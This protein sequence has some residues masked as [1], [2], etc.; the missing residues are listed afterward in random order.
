MS[1]PVSRIWR[2]LAGFVLA[3][4]LVFAQDLPD[5]VRALPPVVITATKGARDL[6]EVAVPMQVLTRQEIAAI[7]A[8][9]LSD[10]LAEQPGLALVQEFGTGVQVQG[11]APDYT[12]ILIDGE[13]VIGRQGGTLNLDRL[14]VGGIER[15]EV[16]K[17]PSS[18]LYGSEA[19][20]GVINL[21]T[22]RPD[23]PLHLT[24][25]ARYETH[26]TLDAT[27]EAAFQ[28]K[29]LGGRVLLNRYGSD[30]YDLARHLPGATTP[31]FTDYTASAHLHV[32]AS[33]RTDLRFA[34]RYGQEQQRNAVGVVDQGIL[35]EYEEAS[36]RDDWSTS[37]TLVYRPGP[38]WRLQSTLY[39]AR[40]MTDTA[41]R[42]PETDV[43]LTQSRFDQFYGKS[44]TQLD[45][46]AGP[47]HLATFGGGLVRESIAADRV[48]GGFRR[49]VAG[50]AFAQ[51]EWQASARLGLVASTRLDAH[52]DYA[53]RVSP[54]LAVRYRAAETLHLRASLGSGFRAPTFQQRYMDFTNAVGGY[55]VYGANEARTVLHELDTQGLLATY[56]VDPS[57]LGEL[58]PESARSLNVGGTYTRPHATLHVNLFRNHVRDLIETGLVAF[59]TN[60]QQVFSYFN[61]HRIYTQGVEVEAE[62][63]PVADLAL[64]LGYQYLDTADRDV[65]A[66]LDAGT[67]FTRDASNRDRRATRRDYGGLFNRSRHSSTLH[68][69]YERRGSTVAL[70]GIWRGRYGHADANGNLILDQATEYVPGYTLWHVTLTQVLGTRLHLQTGLKNLFDH[71]NPIL[72]PS[73]PGR[74]YFV[75]LRL[76]VE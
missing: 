55:A 44:E 3:P 17:G 36:R 13:P 1:A 29:R 59:R 23:A 8:T 15:V 9:R 53:A 67:V 20:A 39:A 72:I 19:L 35:L 73:L 54:K 10:L 76:E 2:L 57:R 51:H 46:I 18:S 6:R 52:P 64:R 48:R 49:N 27:T 21:I 56:V 60:G 12:L 71:T 30:G 63:R 16:V 75:G 34:A 45:W 65:L 50:F 62:L 7:G 70:R 22:R 69:Q 11:F 47:A 28:R 38:A 31:G 14:T 58:R 24:T 4:A 61:L 68:L 37:G 41:V 43:L 66:A 40:F 74:L 42:N 32:E 33:D 5:S 26:Q 25:S